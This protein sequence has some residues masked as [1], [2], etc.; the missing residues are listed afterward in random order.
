MTN[1]NK[2][3]HQTLT[4][5]EMFRRSLENP[6]IAKEFIQTYLPKEISSQI[7]VNT[8][9]LVKETFVEEDLKK[10]LSDVLCKAKFNGVDGYI[11][12]LIEHQSTSEHW[13][14]FRLLK[15]IVNILDHHKRHTESK[16]LPP[17]YATVF[18]TGKS[19]YN[20]PVKLWDLFDNPEIMQQFFTNG[21]NLID[22][23]QIEDKV[24]LQQNLAGVM[25]LVM[26][27]SYERDLDLL[28]NA[29]KAV[30]V[31]EQLYNNPEMMNDF[32]K[33]IL[34]YYNINNK[35]LTKIQN[36]VKEMGVARYYQEGIDEGIQQGIQQ[37]RLHSQIEFVKNMLR[38]GV[39]VESIVKYSKLPK[40]EILKL[41]LQLKSNDN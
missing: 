12:F 23:T 5:D 32:I 27:H 38:D 20:S 40:E 29:L 10:S 18:Y 17:V 30:H 14:S 21:Y 9:A 28:V 1:K 22:L 19:K 39:S 37:E 35:E 7:D 13:M 4:H 41:K 31:L 36:E 26:K 2:K 8:L 3:E 6:I 24:L 34:C 15:Y 11:Y 33:S 25:S 16:K